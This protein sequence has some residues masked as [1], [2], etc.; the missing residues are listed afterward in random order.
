M[1]VGILLAAGSS[2]RFG[3][4]NKLLHPLAGRALVSHAADAIRAVRLD[5][6]IA[7]VSTADVAKHLRDF[8]CV[9]VSAHELSMATSL[10]AGITRAIELDAT[11][12]LIHL[13]DMPAVESQLL[14]EIIENCAEDTPSMTRSGRVKSPPACFPAKLFGQIMQI[15]GDKGARQLL[16]SIAKTRSVIV[17]NS[18]IADIDKPSDIN[19]LQ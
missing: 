8:D 18:M 12:A 19:G 14:Q 2:R 5:K 13:G 11:K 1:I 7:I 16:A 9:D 6:K 17:P 15:D 3:A 10:K 4:A